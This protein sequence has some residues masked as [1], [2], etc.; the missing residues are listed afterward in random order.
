MK[1]YRCFAYTGPGDS[2]A[3]FDRIR[4]APLNVVTAP[5][6]I[7]RQ[8]PIF[9]HVTL[10]VNVQVVWCSRLPPLNNKDLS[11]EPSE[12][13][14]TSSYIEVYGVRKNHAGGHCIPESNFGQP[15]ITR[16]D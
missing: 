11:P 5:A 10:S 12:I 7:F 16:I 1:R 4:I 15:C 8:I 2:S 9:S 6:G 14:P 13:T 3:S